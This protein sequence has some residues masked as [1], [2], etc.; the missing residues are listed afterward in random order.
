MQVAD[1]AH[2]ALIFAV[3]EPET[4]WVIAY[5]LAIGFVVGYRWSYLQ[6]HPL[7]EGRNLG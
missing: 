1:S 2:A 4:I 7:K 5:S 6:I 3:L